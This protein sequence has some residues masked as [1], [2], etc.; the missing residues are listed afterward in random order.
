MKGIS[1]ND[2]RET[3][4]LHLVARMRSEKLSLNDVASELGVGSRNWVFRAT[5]GDD[6]RYEV[7]VPT[8]LLALLDW[9]ALEPRDFQSGTTVSTPG[10]VTQAILSLSGVSLQQQ[11]QLV[12]VVNAFLR[13][14]V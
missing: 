10:H 13:S 6:F 3:L 7:G 12:E 9:L 4:A 14:A 1:A 8:T 11:Q 2:F 5:V